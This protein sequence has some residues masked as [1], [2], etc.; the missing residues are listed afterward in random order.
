MPGPSEPS[1]SAE[2]TATRAGTARVRVVDREALLLDGVR[3]V[4]G[5]ALEV[6]D[7]HLVDDDLH[8]AEVLERVALEHP[9][10]EVEL[11]DQARAAAGLD[12]DTK[13]QVVAPLLLQ[14]AAD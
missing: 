14:E 8:T 9:L 13:A 4:D 11:V 7:A 6:G 10:V 5:R 2:R 12:R 3:E 1:G